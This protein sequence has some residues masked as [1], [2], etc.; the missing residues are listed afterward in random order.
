MKFALIGCADL[1]AGER[2]GTTVGAMTVGVD[3]NKL[4]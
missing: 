3:V 2:W 4:D 1:G